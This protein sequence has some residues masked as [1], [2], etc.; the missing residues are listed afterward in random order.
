M[1]LATSL[2]LCSKTLISINVYLIMVIL[3]SLYDCKTSFVRHAYTARK[4]SWLV[5][6]FKRGVSN[7]SGLR[8]LWGLKKMRRVRSCQPK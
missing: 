8:E 4:I 1:Y 2:S 6:T 3:D 7:V 5:K